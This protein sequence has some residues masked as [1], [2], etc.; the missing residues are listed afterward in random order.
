[1]DVGGTVKRTAALLVGGA[2]VVLGIAMLVLPGPGLLV[3]LAGLLVLAL[4]FPA[5]ERYVDPVRD[6]AL[7]AAEESIASPARLA[8]SVAG[9][10]LLIGAGVVW[11]LVP[12]LPLGGWGT[13]AG[14][15]VSGVVVLGL[16]AYSARRVAR[17]R[18]GSRHPR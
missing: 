5:V 14:L 12:T 2:L 6:R 18:T 17:R 4:K 15:I 13:G 11:G 16:L 3:V 8:A 9:G 1:M 10:V 7:Q